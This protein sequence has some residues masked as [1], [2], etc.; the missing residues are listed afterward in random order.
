MRRRAKEIGIANLDDQI[1]YAKELGLEFNKDDLQALAD[2]AG[3]TKG[4]LSEEQL[5]QIA[6]GCVTLTCAAVVSA[7]GVVAGV[8]VGALAGAASSNTW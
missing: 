8:G 6:G 3:I 1:A 2:E 5:E 4:E 7:V